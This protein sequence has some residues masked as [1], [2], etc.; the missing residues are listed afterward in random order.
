MYEYCIIASPSIIV[1]FAAYMRWIY[2]M[3][4]LRLTNSQLQLSIDI[5]KDAGQVFFG[6]IIIPY[7]LGGITLLMLL[8]GVIMCSLCWVFAFL[9]A[10]Q[11]KSI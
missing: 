2:N 3:S 7:F 5:L 10:R 9:I 11:L 8:G 6:S 1:Q 4:T